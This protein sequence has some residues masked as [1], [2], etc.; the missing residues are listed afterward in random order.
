MKDRDIQWVRHQLDS[1]T[2]ARTCGGFSPADA[3]QYLE[4]CG[5]EAT[6]IGH[7]HP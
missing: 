7:P 6:L 3:V 4:L 5:L 2:M 1:L